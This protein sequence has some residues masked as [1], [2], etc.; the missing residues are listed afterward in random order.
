MNE[1]INISLRF[2]INHVSVVFV[3][4]PVFGNTILQPSSPMMDTSIHEKKG[5][6]FHGFVERMPSQQPWPFWNL[7]FLCFPSTGGGKLTKKLGKISVCWEKLIAFL[8]VV[9]FCWT[10][11][12]GVM[13]FL[14][15]PMVDAHYNPSN[16]CF[17]TW[18]LKEI[19]KRITKKKL[20]CL[21]LGNIFCQ[22]VYDNCLVTL[23]TWNLSP[24]SSW[25][26]QNPP[27]IPKLRW[28][29]FGV[30]GVQTSSKC[31]VEQNMG[32][33]KNNDTPKSSICS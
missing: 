11:R 28:T 7:D 6:R 3:A 26:T 30:M 24:V 27:V 8:F 5:R 31:L 23:K 14:V 2:P 21:F 13:N 19:S 15:R 32:V 4:P 22:V 16:Q 1:T 17:E 25:L 18:M 12:G 20:A 9:I 10:S 29:V 33:S